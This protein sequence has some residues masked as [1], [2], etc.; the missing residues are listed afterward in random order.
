[1]QRTR[2]GNLF[3]CFFVLPYSFFAPAAD[4]LVKYATS[5]DAGGWFLPGAHQDGSFLPGTHQ[6]GSFLSG[7]HQ[8]G[9]FLTKACEDNQEE[10]QSCQEPGRTI[11]EH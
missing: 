2:A 7:L 3:G 11:K 1:M 9:S 8:D 4:S 6:D 5:C 10:N